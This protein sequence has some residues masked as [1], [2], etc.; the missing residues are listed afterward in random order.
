[1][2]KTARILLT[3]GKTENHLFRREDD[4]GQ[5]ETNF[6]VRG[7]RGSTDPSFHIGKAYWG[8]GQDRLH[9]FQ[10]AMNPDGFLR[11][12][13][14]ELSPCP[15]CSRPYEDKQ[16]VIED[17]YGRTYTMEEFKQMINACP[18]QPRDKVGQEFA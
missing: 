7:Y 14:I 3:A 12:E 10:W 11:Q 8:E 4:M 15:T 9:T 1:M 6:Y 18:N 5:M 2:T 13:N 17:D 16:N